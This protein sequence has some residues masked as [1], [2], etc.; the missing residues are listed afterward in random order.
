MTRTPLEVV[1]VGV[2]RM[3]APMAR[4]L[5]AGGY[6]VKVR[7]ASEDAVQALVREDDQIQEF[8][9]EWEAVRC[10][11]LMLPNS[12]IVDQAL[13]L[14]D[15]FARIPGASIVIDMSS[16]DPIR[17]RDLGERFR[18]RGVHY[19]DAPVSGGIR[20]A[21]SGTLSIMVGGSWEHFDAVRPLFNEL[22]DQVF[23]VGGLGAGHAAKALNN[24]VSAATT[25]VTVEAMRTAAAFGI[26]E[27]TFLE[28]LNASSGRSNM[29]ENKAKQYM[30]SGEFNFGFTIALTS[31]DVDI[32]ANL[33]TK[34]GIDAELVGDTAK[35]WAQMVEDGHGSEDHTLVYRYL[36]RRR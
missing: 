19:L 5:T 9:G 27:A 17:S 21:E 34:L 15:A 36:N 30:L 31:K 18:R 26:N 6:R 12:D 11:I 16:S 24:A 20:G 8:D 1:F 22:G 3:G 14:D 23:H 35:L 33:A 25:A 4:R 32:A 7:D 28:V 2:G 10:V 29:S 13:K